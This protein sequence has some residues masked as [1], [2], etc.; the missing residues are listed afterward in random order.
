MHLSLSLPKDLVTLRFPEQLSDQE[1][2]EFC[3]LNGELHI[4]REPDGTIMVMTP[5][6]LISG[7]LE[8]DFITDLKIWSRATGGGKVFS[9]ATGFTLPDTSVRS[10]DASW[11]SDEQV[12]QLPEDELQRFAEIV[13]SFVVEVQSRTDLLKVLQRKMKTT[14]I[15]NGVRL[16]WLVIPQKEQLI[17]YR[18]DGTETLIDSFEQEVGGEDLLVDFVFDL[19]ILQKKKDHDH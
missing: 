18:A 4:E 16:A 1:F 8:S 9:S 17:I 15:A 12:A 5:V 10:P 19:R 6:N 11:I 13:P 14:W 3:S 2:Q 7:E